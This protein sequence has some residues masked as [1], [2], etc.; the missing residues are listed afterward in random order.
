[1]F[2]RVS[3]IFL[4]IL[5]C[6]ISAM[7]QGIL[8]PELVH[9]RLSGLSGSS[10]HRLAVING[11]TFSPDEV[12]NI[13]VAG[14][15]ITVKCLEIGET[16]VIVQIGDLTSHYR[17]TMSGEISVVAEI[18]IAAPPVKPVIATASSAPA[19]TSA[20]KPN[21]LRPATIQPSRRVDF[22]YHFLTPIILTGEAVLFLLCG[23]A[24]GIRVGKYLYRKNEGEALVAETIDRHFKPIHLLVN[25]LTLPA[26]GGTTQIDHVIVTS[27]GIFVIETKHY[28]GWIFGNPQESQWTQQICL[29]KFCFQNP[30]RQNYA[31]VKV[32]QALFDLPEDHFHSV[33][34]FTG[35]ARFK[36]DLGP[37]V[38]MLAGLIP[39]LTAER[40][41]LFDERQ[42]AQIVG[43]IEMKRN[44]R[45]V[46]TDEYHINH[47]RRKIADKI[48]PPPKPIASPF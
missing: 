37:N 19:W 18:P 16:F 22:R 7:A 28:S 4:L 35:D 20:V 42:M 36:T 9:I 47:V 14:K 29:K 30:L 13:K 23:I 12:N 1:M 17:L 27:T 45:S 2:W 34:V 8:P 41:V 46:E 39:F 44:R 24:L 25:N 48:P 32:L 33:V 3:F 15:I 10:D 40:P 11:K 26:N 43:W 31:R 5:G 38:L 6:Q 21:V